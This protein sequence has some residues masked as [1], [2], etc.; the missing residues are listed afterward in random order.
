MLVA[1]FTSDR[2]AK[3]L[4]Y[5]DDP[6]EAPFLRLGKPGLPS[7]F[8][9]LRGKGLGRYKAHPSLTPGQILSTMPFHPNDTARKDQQN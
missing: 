5:G 2:S 3:D 8:A 9:S 6:A 7:V 4:G 1:H